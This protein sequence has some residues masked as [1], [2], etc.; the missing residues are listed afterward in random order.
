MITRLGQK[1]TLDLL[2]Q[3]LMNG[4]VVLLENIGE[5]LD[6]VLDSLLARNLIKKGRS[7][8]GL[9]LYFVGKGDCLELPS[10]KMYSQIRERTNRRFE[11]V[12]LLRLS[13]FR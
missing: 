3:G 6:P 5:V 10:I 12:E 2:E 9:N 8:V 4:K 13:Y 11:V 1:N 7:V